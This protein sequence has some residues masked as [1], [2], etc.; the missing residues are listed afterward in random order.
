MIFEHYDGNGDGTISVEELISVFKQLGVDV[1]DSEKVSSIISSLDVDSDG[2][3]TKDNFISWW[4]SSSAN[5][6]EFDSAVRSLLF[7]YGMNFVGQKSDELHAF[8]Q[9]LNRIFTEYLGEAE[10]RK[11]AQS[12]TKEEVGVFERYLPID[13]ADGGHDILSKLV[14]GVLLAKMINLAVPDT[15]DERV[16]HLRDIRTDSIEPKHIVENLNIVLSSCKAIGVPFGSYVRK[17]EENENKNV[18]VEQLLDP[19]HYEDLVRHILSEL[20]KMHLSATINLKDNPVLIR[21]AH[22]WEDDDTIKSL[23][24]T[25]W[26]KRWINYQLKRSGEDLRIK[27]FGKE[28]SDGAVLAHVLRSVTKRKKKKV[29]RFDDRAA[30]E[31]PSYARAAYILKVLQSQFNLNIFLSAND[32]L[33]GNRRLICLLCAQIFDRFKGMKRITNDEQQQIDAMYSN[34]AA[35]T[36]SNSNEVTVNHQ[37]KRKK[38]KEG[39]WDT[40]TGKSKKKRA[41]GSMNSKSMQMMNVDDL[42]E[43]EQREEQDE[44]DVERDIREEKD[45]VKWINEILAASKV[46]DK[47]NEHQMKISNV[48]KDLR[49]G[50]V[51]LSLIALM[52]PE[53]VDWSNVNMVSMVEPVRLQCLANC[54][55]IVS[56]I[57]REPLCVSFFGIERVPSDGKEIYNGNKE[58]IF[59][60]CHN[61]INYHY[62]SM[63]TELLSS[64][65]ILSELDILHWTK[66]QLQRKLKYPRFC[67]FEEKSLHS[68]KDES[69]KSCLYFMDLL[70]MLMDDRS[71]IDR[72]VV[73]HKNNRQFRDG[74]YTKSECLSNARY[75]LSIARK[76]GGVFYISPYDL[77]NVRSPEIT[78]SFVMCI[79]VLIL[80]KHKKHK[81]HGKT[82]KKSSST[83]KHNKKDKAKDGDHK[84]DIVDVLQIHLE[85]QNES[86]ADSNA[87]SSSTVCSD[88]VNPSNPKKRKSVLQ[89]FGLITDEQQLQELQDISRQYSSPNIQRLSASSSAL[90]LQ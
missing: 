82:K 34:E 42:K 38:Y 72:D 12:N 79:M 27:R 83:S 32:I 16:L 29:E 49:D 50:V 14:D 63:L 60:I 15:I 40:R 73:I 17:N 2:I 67:C 11:Y 54:H 70:L 55:Y 41:R 47:R 68:F 30:L 28:F 81:I 10:N 33:C 69:L 71:D 43:E 59:K 23:P 25:T 51:L 45:I 26:L 89:D 87:S 76:F 48:T 22:E 31:K 19:S 86:K 9:Y 61:L 75:A 77:V 64:D 36:N 5:L 80:E 84:E 21:L 74:D 13:P 24:A 44:D 56:L 88:D 85:Q 7:L 20:S 78:M 39:D 90:N 53:S 66:E 37:Q 62:L 46:N 4:F 8:A 6:V 3:V 18:S 1:T 58:L 52:S 57:K 65:H 35:T